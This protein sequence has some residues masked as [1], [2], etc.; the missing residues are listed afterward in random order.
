M[1]EALEE[2]D[3]A[4]LKGEVPVGAVLV[5]EGKII[6]RAHNLVETCQDAT[7][8][9]EILC[10]REGMRQLNNWR[11][12]GTTLYTT[13]EPCT[14]CAGALFLSRVSCLVWGAPDTRHGANGSWVD[15]FSL[16]HPTHR[17]EVRTHVLSELSSEKMRLFF[18]K[19]RG[20]CAHSIQRTN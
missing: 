11:L 13:L 14:L 2:A 15:V 6:A 18:Q 8:H 16:K 7:A 12:V 17:V 20:R 3:K 4:F 19:Q 9:A 5:R 10:L 1:K